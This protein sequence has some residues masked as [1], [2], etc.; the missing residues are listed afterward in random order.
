MNDRYGGRG[1]LVVAWVLSSFLL[2]AVPAQAATG[3]PGAD[4]GFENL[5]WGD[6]IAQA[7]K[8]YPD[9]Y[10]EG[11]RIVNEK[12]EPSKIY[13]R[14]KGTGRIDG[15]VFDSIE[16]WF[17]NDRFYEIRAVKTSNIGPR[18]LVTQA[19]RS[20]GILMDH[21]RQTYG[22]PREYKVNYHAEDLSV[23]KEATWRIREV[24][25]FLKYIGVTK[26]DTDQLVFEM[27]KQGGAP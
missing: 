15:V 21:M 5:K 27:R 10:F 22:R 8:T 18:T 2:N 12:E 6:S 25:I 17:R 20:H 26:G 3:N 19:E 13:S 24:W 23:V 4:E 9:L 11:Y 1:F 14:R 16:Y 7:L